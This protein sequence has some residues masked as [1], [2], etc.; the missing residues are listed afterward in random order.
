LRTLGGARICG[1]WRIALRA[2]TLIRST[3]L[4][5]NHLTI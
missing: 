5:L 2:Y 4:L 1:G 3:S